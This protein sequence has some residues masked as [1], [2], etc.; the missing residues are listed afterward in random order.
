M[1]LIHRRLV[2]EHPN[3]QVFITNA[4]PKN[5]MKENTRRIAENLPG[6]PSFEDGV[7]YFLFDEGQTTYWDDPLWVVFKNHIQSSDKGV[8]AILFC[9]YGN[10]SVSDDPSITPPGFGNGR[11]T[12]ERMDRKVS[13]PCG[14]L[15][16]A[17]EFREVIRLRPKLRLADDLCEF[18]YEYTQG[19]VGAIVAVLDFLL[20]KVPT[21]E[22]RI[23]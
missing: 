8:Y 19:H 20:K 11:V 16:D 12:L 23:T 13:K 21:C 9:S 5:I 14:L 3:A 15:L 2:N 18:V 6:Y 22:S 7:R 1:N 17:E 4:W 10:E